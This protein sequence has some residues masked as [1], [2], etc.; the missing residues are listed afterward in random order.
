MSDMNVLKIHDGDGP[1]VV[2]VAAGS[3]CTPA[4]QAI[5]DHFGESKVIIDLSSIGDPTPIVAS[6]AHVDDVVFCFIAPGFYPADQE[7]IRRWLM[8]HEY[9]HHLVQYL[10]DIYVVVCLEELHGNKQE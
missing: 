8:A 9:N 5:M 3:G 7:D 1:P 10:G 2:V 4:Y 6:Q